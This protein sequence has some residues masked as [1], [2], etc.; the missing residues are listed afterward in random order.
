MDVIPT[1]TCLSHPTLSPVKAMSHGRHKPKITVIIIIN[2]VSH[3]RQSPNAE[4]LTKCLVYVFEG[5]KL[6]I[7]HKKYVKNVKFLVYEKI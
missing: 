6:I 5:K 1:I 3:F 2:V 7:I 4:I